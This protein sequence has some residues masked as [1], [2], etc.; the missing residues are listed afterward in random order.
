MAGQPY[1]RM[2][3][4]SFDTAMPTQDAGFI[5]EPGFQ[6]LNIFDKSF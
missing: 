4:A 1:A 2:K 5:G 6:E 3:P